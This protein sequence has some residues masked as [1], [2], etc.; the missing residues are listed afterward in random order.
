MDVIAGYLKMGGFILWIH[1]VMSVLALAVVIERFTNLRKARIVPDVLA[2]RAMALWREDKP[3]E[4]ASLCAGDKSILARV[5]E[6]LVEQRGNADVAQV[7]MF[8]EDKAA[9]ELRLE[10]RRA[11]QISII[12]TLS[13]LVGLF[14]TVVGLLRAFQTVAEVG[15]MGD[16]AI[17]ANDIGMAL[18]T[19]VSGLALAMP[20]LFV[21][22]QLRSRIGLFA[23]LLE[24]EVSALVN[25]WFVKK[26]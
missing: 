6:T 18:I 4:L 24:E 21:Y 23:V 26:G 1:I 9:R 15:E 13:P 11:S 3:A 17:L 2:T 20:A 12:A 22:H 16:P 7:K 25:A 10:A 5:I 19:T 8:A 14:G